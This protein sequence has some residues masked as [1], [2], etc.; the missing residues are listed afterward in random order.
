MS[1]RG[2]ARWRRAV[3]ALLLAPCPALWLAVAAAVPIA[4]SVWWLMSPPLMVLRQGPVDL[5]FNLAGAW[6]VYN[7]QVPHVDFHE[8]VGQLNFWLTAIGFHLIGPTPRAFLLGELLALAVVLPIALFT[9]W[10]RLPLAAALSFA[11]FASLPIIIP[12]NI[13]ELDTF[14]FAMSYNRFGWCAISVLALILFVPPRAESRFDGVDVAAG[15]VLLLGLFYVKITYFL[16]GAAAVALALVVCAHVRTRRYAWSGVFLLAAVNAALPHSHPYL[17]DLWRTARF[18]PRT[19]AGVFVHSILNNAAEYSLCG[20]GLI[21]GVWSWQRGVAPPRVPVVAAFLIAASMLLISHN[22]QVR[23][24]PLAT[25]IAYVLYAAVTQRDVAGRLTDT[26][27]LLM[28]LLVFPALSVA[29]SLGSIAAYHRTATNRDAL[30]EVERSNLRGLA[31]PRGSGPRQPVQLEYLDTVV[32]AVA[33]LQARPVHGPIV[34]LD[35]V[36]PFPFALGQVPARGGDLFG[37]LPLPLRPADEIFGEAAHV[38]VP[39]QS[40]SPRW[41]ANAV[42]HYSGYLAERFPV[43]EEHQH[44]TLLSRR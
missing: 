38:L 4:A 1:D 44:W 41:T 36:D 40:S 18:G 34:N 3:T 24:V 5:L 26:G 14:S 31:I 22:T 37:D 16:V 29:S 15:A 30:H 12:V 23:G 32:D 9:A 27:L 11:L 39:K 10:R 42:A 13:G 25:V 28:A 2:A 17:D 6:R 33:L 43:R 8:P 21:A 19:S 20:L 35:R 7:G